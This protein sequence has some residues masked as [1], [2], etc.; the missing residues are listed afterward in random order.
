[1]RSGGAPYCSRESN[2]RGA[3][4]NHR[5]FVTETAISGNAN[6]LNSDRGGRGFGVARRGRGHR[7]GHDRA[8]GDD[9]GSQIL[10]HDVFLHVTSS[11]K[12]AAT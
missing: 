4:Q 6:L 10:T 11:I 8:P 2:E 7:R 9:Q 1:M 3:D 5:G 12:Y